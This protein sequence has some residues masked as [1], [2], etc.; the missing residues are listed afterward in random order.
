MQTE[1]DVSLVN[2]RV[3]TT[4]WIQPASRPSQ[5]SEDAHFFA[6]QMGHSTRPFN[7][8]AP[9]DISNILTDASA[10]LV[11]STNRMSKGLKA[12]NTSNNEKEKLNYSTELSNTML[13]TQVLAKSVGKTAQLVEKISNLQ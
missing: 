11:K 9:T 1:N 6:S 7:T 2:T 3:T 4:S 5:G 8:A 10:L 12:F 13:L